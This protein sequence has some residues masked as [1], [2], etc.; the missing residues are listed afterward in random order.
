MSNIADI[1]T[2]IVI[3]VDNSPSISPLNRSAIA[4][5]Q[6]LVEAIRTHDKLNVT[7]VGLVSWSD[8]NNSRIEVPI[9]NNYDRIVTNAS[10]IKFAEGKHP[11][12]QNGLDAALDAFKKAGIAKGRDKKIVIITDADNDSYQKPVNMEYSGYAIFAVVVGD[13]TDTEPFKMLE[14]LTKDHKGYVVSLNNLSGLRGIFAQM[15]TAGSRIKNVHL[16][17]VLP[18]Y[19]VLLNSTATEDKGKIRLNGDNADST[20]TTIDWDIGDLSECWST[21]FRE[22]SAGSCP[23]MSINLCRFHLLTIL[24]KEG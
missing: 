8:K 13:N 20:T 11:N 15:A 1:P 16:A 4:G 17:E 14:A 5:V 21:D 22:F 18:T 19:L 3:A 24:T 12:Y 9:T 2:D 23:Q 6:N 7:R 10:S